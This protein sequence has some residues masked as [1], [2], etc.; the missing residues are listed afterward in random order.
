MC[1]VRNRREPYGTNSECIRAEHFLNLKQK[2]QAGYMPKI[3]YI[4]YI[5]TLS[6]PTYNH[7]FDLAV[8]DEF[9]LFFFLKNFVTENVSNGIRL[10]RRLK[11]RTTK[12]KYNELV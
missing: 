4:V 12:V 6:T 3:N 7:I 9:S 5:S 2:I 11:S 8:I 10:S 1:D